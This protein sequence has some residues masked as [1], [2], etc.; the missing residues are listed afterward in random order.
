MT[1]K[2]LA[3]DLPLQGRQWIEASA[4]TGKT[5][6][7][8]LLVLR[9]LLER[10]VPLPNIL[11]V[12]F[13]KAAT[14][15]LKI[16]IRA[17]IKL[18]QD[19]L[20]QDLSAGLDGLDAAAQATATLLQ[21]L[22]QKKTKKSVQHE[23]ELAI[24]DC[25]RVS[26]FTIH[27]FCAR[28]LGDHALSAGQVLQTRTV[29]TSTAALNTKIA[30][31]LWR[32]FSADRERM[33]SLVKLW[34][35]PELLAKQC[36]SLLQAENLLP[37]F[38]GQLPDEF[39]MTALNRRLRSSIEMHLDTARDL[40][41]QTQ[42]SGILHKSHM[43]Q[44]I[45]DTAFEKLEI[46]HSLNNEQPYED[47]GFVRLSDLH[48]A[49]KISKSNQGKVPKSELFES[50]GLWY[51]GFAQVQAFEEARDIQCM[52]WVRER[53]A[54]RREALLQ[55]LQQYSYDDLINQVVRAL[56]G[57]SGAALCEA[58]RKEYPVALVDEFQ[59]T[60][61]QQWKIFSTLYPGHLPQHALYL[62]GD[63]KQAIY[64]FRG[65]DVHAYLAA[66]HESQQQWD[67]PE[68]FRSR[69][70]LL[71]AVATLFEQGGTN[72]FREPDIHFYPVQAGGAVQDG[73][74]LWHDEP[75][76]A[77]QL[78]LLPE[79]IDQ[80][81]EKAAPL[82]A[83]KAR[84]LATRAC[85]EKIH[86]VLLAGQNHQALLKDKDGMRGV[87][88]GDIAVLVNQ[89]KEAVEI[90]AALSTCG[91]ASVISSQENLFTTFEAH[92]LFVILDALI[93][94]QDQARWHGALSTVLLGYHAEQI[95]QLASDDI[96]A[97]R[98]ADLAVQYRDI[99]L[100]Q[101]VLSLVSQLCSV[102]A[103]RLLSLANGERRLSNYLQLAET[104]QQASALI[105]GPEQCL[106]WLGQAM[107]DA[108]V[109]EENTLRLDSD[110]KRVKILTLHKSKGLEFPL[111]FM[112]FASFGKTA[113]TGAGLNLLNYH[114]QHR[115][116]THALVY[117]DNTKKQLIE[118][119]KSRS[120]EEQLAEQIRLLYVGLTRARHYCWVCC[121]L[122]NKNDKNS[123]SSLLFR[124]EKDEIKTP[125]HAEF[126][127]RL[128]NIH[129]HNGNILI[130][131]ISGQKQT[132]PLFN[133]NQDIQRIQ[134]AQPAT[135]IQ[136]DW[137]VLS[138]SQLTHGSHHQ[139]PSVTPAADEVE[140]SGNLL[141][142]TEEVFDRRF[143][144]TAFGNALHHALENT[145]IKAWREHEDVNS[146]PAS[147]QAL[148]QQSLLRQGYTQ[149]E[150]PDGTNQLSPLIFNT[151]RTCLPEGLRLC[152]LP[153]NA[154]LNE[155]EFH[156]SLRECETKNLLDLLKQYGVLQQR[157][158]F[159]FL[160]RL[161]G[162]MT[163][164]ID[165]TYRHDGR[166]YVC[167]YKS[168]RLS[169]YDADT[170]KQAM[171]DSEYDF[172]ALIYTL[173]LHRWCKFRLRSSYGYETH[174]GGI[175]YLF[176][177]G[178][179]ASTNNGEGIVAMRFERELIEQLER[180]L[181]PLAE[182]TI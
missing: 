115:R 147:E 87:L 56:E 28:V 163:G 177:R 1:R 114:E 96:A 69:P 105:L 9:L 2:P 142:V 90:Q 138:F 64:G 126:L 121:G 89:N 130:E 48:I 94:H 109:D 141:P 72:A 45:I 67:L 182:Q 19:L 164:K 171:R 122:I 125:L 113:K 92:E 98:S 117:D 74:F 148:L 78:A 124:N 14:Q 52:H 61:S 86:N 118:S 47:P 151:L 70:R 173:A 79:Y 11:A 137:R 165:L 155:M 99:W 30:F 13:T 166:F 107:Q 181:H 111:V 23:L 21:A 50:I 7:L 18:A 75:A 101:G 145:N 128:E 91:I 108:S 136:Q 33:R 10:E 46:W 40:M 162:L 41:R 49:G 71:S 6:T 44:S 139:N 93:K 112:P 84:E 82:P 133:D 60:D 95:L 178:L 27:G 81:K 154:C 39:D 38:P 65:G 134:V 51:Q 55:K 53:L 159:P 80:Q 168:N 152:D 160:R 5:F 161:N 156:F 103:S 120:A 88:P 149:E 24:Q 85:V 144:G 100:H 140:M 29:L 26:I 43:S 116:I 123:L 153:E 170:C 180:L 76:P 59:D 176:V 150:L 16:K 143:A 63:P 17:Q 31:D 157:E 158:E 73:D 97:T 179:D 131:E 110:Q 15:E 32:E 42:L 102:A 83:G 172:Q 129:Q 54:A 12:T 20:K 169:G 34:P 167:D 22:L 68:N 3:L 106:R 174:M 62:I 8:S 57:E 175:R 119:I 104:L 135:H 127:A 58:L 25:D 37:E 66:K 4:G 36:D 146:T 77:M 132:L 35:S